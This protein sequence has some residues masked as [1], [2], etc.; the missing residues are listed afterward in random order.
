MGD[1]AVRTGELCAAVLTLT[2]LSWRARIGDSAA[3]DCFATEASVEVT[4][5]CAGVAAGTA[6]GTADT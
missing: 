1:S 5:D 3:A 6:V 2:V 4:A